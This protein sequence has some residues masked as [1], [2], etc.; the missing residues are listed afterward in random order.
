MNSP[1]PQAETWT[2][3]PAH[4][5]K[6]PPGS[7]TRTAFIVTDPVSSVDG[8]GRPVPPR[9]CHVSPY[10]RNTPVSSNPVRRDPDS[11]TSRGHI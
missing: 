6:A 3:S 11:T 7:V 5:T 9:L 4:N 2:Q 8:E 1:N 10:Y